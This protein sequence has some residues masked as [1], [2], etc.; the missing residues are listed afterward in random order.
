V[1]ATGEDDREPAQ[2]GDD[3]QSPGA[4]EQRPPEEAA[5]RQRE[6]A[7][8]VGDLFETFEL[9]VWPVEVGLGEHRRE[10]VER[11]QDRGEDDTEHGESG[12]GRHDVATAD[13][14]RAEQRNRVVHREREV[15]LGDVPRPP[16]QQRPAERV[17][18]RPEPQHGEAAEDVDPRER[19][20]GEG[21]GHPDDAGGHEPQLRG[22]ESPRV[23][24]DVRPDG[25][26]LGHRVHD[27]HADPPRDQQVDVCQPAET[28][29][30]PCRVEN[31]DA[32]A[33]DEQRQPDREV[34]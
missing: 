34:P 4:G 27:R 25:D 23:Q 21:G 32:G 19:T 9:D 31:A 6:D 26:E 17:D 3:Q 14:E 29:D 24:G 16:A 12:V 1:K 22:C 15:A 13:R 30:E 5:G 20:R 7:R 28:G 18:E 8:R 2:H 11:A 33:G 10:L